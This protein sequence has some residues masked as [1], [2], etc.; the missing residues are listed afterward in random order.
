[1]YIEDVE[2]KQGKQHKH[3]S[4]RLTDG[5]TKRHTRQACETYSVHVL[6]KVY[7]HSLRP[8]NVRAGGVIREKNDE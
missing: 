4:E 1:M 6:G 5:W 8:N 3:A 2:S 7:S